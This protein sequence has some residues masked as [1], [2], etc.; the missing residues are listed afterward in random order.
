MGKK[1]GEGNET[2]S[3]AL[4]AAQAAA[5]KKEFDKANEL[6]E[7]AGTAAPASFKKKMADEAAAQ[8]A[9]QRFDAALAANDPD[10]A[11]IEFDRCSSEETYYCGKVKEKEDA[12]KASFAKKH[13]AAAAAAKGSNPTLCSDE[14][15]KVLALEPGNAEAQTLSQQCS[16]ASAAAPPPPPKPAAPS[17]PSQA[18]R[19]AQANELLSTATRE[20]GA[21]DLP[22]ALRDLNE[23]VE[24]KPSQSVVVL[25]Y[26]NLGVVNARAAKYP[27]AAKWLRKYQPFCK[28]NECDTIKQLIAKYGG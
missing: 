21:G 19:D 16:P 27:D 2:G 15:G 7:S 4:K 26:R 24:K 22:G 18:Q 20:V 10:K 25:C 17:G 6:A 1:G 23:C 9:S 13:L 28:P 8:E 3:S 11:K 14:V 12:F 5:A